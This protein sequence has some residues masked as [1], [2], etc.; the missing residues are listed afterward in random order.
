MENWNDDLGTPA[1][2]YDTYCGFYELVNAENCDADLD[3]PAPYFCFNMDWAPYFNM[4]W[5]FYELTNAENWDYDH[6]ENPAPYYNMHRGIY[7]VAGVH[8]DENGEDGENDSGF[9]DEV[10]EDD[11]NSGIGV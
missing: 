10:D 2:Y 4:H 1:P 9:G 6:L 7:E 5:G 3:T 11:N 8:Y